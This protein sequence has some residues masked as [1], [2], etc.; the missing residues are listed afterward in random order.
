MVFDTVL[1][2]ISTQSI[3]PFVAVPV[4][5]AL[6][7]V[8]AVHC[9]VLRAAR[10]TSLSLAFL[11]TLQLPMVTHFFFRKTLEWFTG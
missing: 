6:F 8:I 4:L 5:F 2:L 3:R 9:N 10:V 7:L 1:G 11:N